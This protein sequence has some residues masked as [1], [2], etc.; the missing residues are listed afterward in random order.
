MPLLVKVSVMGGEVAYLR[1]E[2]INSQNFVQSVGFPVA[3]VQFNY[4][5]QIIH[6]NSTVVKGH[7]NLSP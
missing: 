5:N 7:F 4:E 1:L 2:H 6:R 3:S